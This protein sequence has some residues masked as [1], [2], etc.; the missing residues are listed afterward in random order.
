[1]DIL[2]MGRILSSNIVGMSGWLIS[3]MFTYSINMLI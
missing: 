2:I 3:Y 1:M